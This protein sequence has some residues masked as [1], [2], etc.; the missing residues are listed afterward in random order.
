MKS[1]EAFQDRACERWTCRDC[2]RF[3][4]SKL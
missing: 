4:W 2:L 3:F 1:E